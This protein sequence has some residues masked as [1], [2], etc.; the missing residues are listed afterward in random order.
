MPNRR[1]AILP[2]MALCGPLLIAA[3]LLSCVRGGDGD[4][5]KRLAAADTATQA[6][7]D[8]VEMVAYVGGVTL[9]HVRSPSGGIEEGRITV[10]GRVVLAEK[11]NGGMEMVAYWPLPGDRT[12]V[13][14]GI[15]FGGIVCERS[16]RVLELRP[17]ADPLLTEEFGSCAL[18]PDT[19]WFDRSGA[20]WMRFPDWASPRVTMEEGDDFV[21]GPPETYVYRGGGRIQ[22][23]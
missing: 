10:D 5:P 22:S 13:L 19:M 15:A 8:S 3:A 18:M 17:G 11:L 21:P 14:L 1:A 2:L 7:R 16:F 9:E 12:L 4:A 6:E 23:P 20:L